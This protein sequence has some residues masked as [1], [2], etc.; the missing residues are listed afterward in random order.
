MF[1]VMGDLLQDLVVWQLE[2][3]RQ[4]SDTRS[5]IVSRR[6]GSAANVAAFAA[7]YY[8]TRFLG[9]VGSDIPGDMLVRDLSAHEVDVRVQRADKTGVVVVMINQD[10]ER[11]MYPSRAASTRIQPVD[12]E[13][14]EGIE[15]VHCPA[16]GLD[17]GDTAATVRDTL[18]RVHANG[19]QS[20]IDASS[21]AVLRSIGIDMFWEFLEQVGPDFLSANRDECAALGLLRHNE[22]GPNAGRLPGTVVIARSGS[23]PT[24][25]FTGG[26]ETAAV[27][28]PPAPDVR[29]VTGA[30]DA[31]N[32]GFLTAH[33]QGDDSQTACRAGHAFA[34]RV[35]TAPGAATS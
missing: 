26:R 8:P 30:G 7:P 5:E 33:L 25:I 34:A 32:A 27:P 18:Q 2:P 21:V 4:A 22:P 28:V 24:R 11:A 12:D 14:L 35:L 3:T 6:G 15:L 17:G 19:G 20:S 31:F 29:D 10:G 23:D 1:A 16:Y 9:C 13:W